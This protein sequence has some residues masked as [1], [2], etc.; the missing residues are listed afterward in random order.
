MIYIRR[1]LAPKSVIKMVP[2][3][4]VASGI[5]SNCKNDNQKFVN[6]YGCAAKACLAAQDRIFS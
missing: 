5:C 2:G 6:Y 3:D 1:K 4:P